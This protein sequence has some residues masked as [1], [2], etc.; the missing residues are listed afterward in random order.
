M[1]IFLKEGIA[2]SL[3]KD[4]GA[5]A[6]PKAV[7]ILLGL[8]GSVAT[9][10]ASKL[11][12]QL[13][14][15]AGPKGEVRVVLTD[16]ATKF[17]DKTR[18]AEQ[19]RSY[20]LAT[21]IGCR[22]YTDEEEWKWR[23]RLPETS[24]GFR[25]YYQENDPICHI[26][27]RKWADVFVIAP[28]SAN[29]LAKMSN[30]ICDNLLTSIFL[31]WD[32]TKNVVVAP[33]MN[34]F[35]WQ[36]PQTR[37]NIANLKNLFG[38]NLTFVNPVHKELACGDTGIGAMA[39][40]ED[41]CQATSDASNWLF[42][43]DFCYGIPVGQHPGAFRFKRKNST[44]SGVDLYTKEHY[45]VK[46]IE[47]GIVVGIENFTG[48][49]D[50]S[51]WWNDT[52]AVL[53]EGKSGV[54]CYGEIITKH[55]FPIHVG[56]YIQRGQNFA[57]VIPV[58]KEGRERPDIPGHSRSMLHI[59]LYKHGQHKASTNAFQDFISDPTPF[60]I[61]SVNAPPVLSEVSEEWVNKYLLEEKIVST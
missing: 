44:H 38:M 7:N 10:L 31:A 15:I 50:N 55:H 28:L 20:V 9:T 33:A 3:T 51:P 14:V 18:H 12:E 25:Y 46:A 1:E 37:R 41:I 11:V 27:L 13:K 53:I 42:P 57:S 32:W 8:T 56:Q 21:K 61:K 29:T 30:G 48:P 17:F 40:I 60:L 45:W 24:I 19:T 47:T 39:R 6:I 52:E 16:S 54:I 23:D 5:S 4:Q 43:L 26:E 22:V 35:M 36:A 58:L 34:T 49:S 59:E 2:N